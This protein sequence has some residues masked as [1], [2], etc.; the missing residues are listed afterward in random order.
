M[1]AVPVVHLFQVC[2][3]VALRIR[4]TVDTDLFLCSLVLKHTLIY[5]SVYCHRAEVGIAEES[6]A[7]PSE[8]LKAGRANPLKQL[9][10]M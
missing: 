1:P 3:Y 5:L 4:K 8:C 6:A 10:E 7:F 2:S 9:V